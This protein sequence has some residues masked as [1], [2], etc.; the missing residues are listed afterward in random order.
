MCSLTF[1]LAL[2]FAL[3]FTA[4]ESSYALVFVRVLPSSRF[5]GSKRESSSLEMAPGDTD[6]TDAV[7]QGRVIEKLL[8][9]ALKLVQK[10]Q[11][12]GADDDVEAKTGIAR[13]SFM[14][15]HKEV[16]VLDGLDA[17]TQY[18]ALPPSEYSA[19]SSNL[20]T[21]KGDGSTDTFSV[22]IPINSG[23]SR[24]SGINASAD[25]VVSPDPRN[26]EIEIKSGSIYLQASA[27]PPSERRSND[28]SADT[29]QTG[30]STESDSND[31]A[32]KKILPAWLIAEEQEGVDSL[33]ASIQAGFCVT[34]VWDTTETKSK[35]NQASLLRKKRRTFNDD[36]DDNDALP[37]SAKVQV[38]VDLNLPLR[39]DVARAL[40]FPPV[41][42][43]ITQAGTLIART[44]IMSV[45]P[46]LADLLVQDFNCRKSPQSS[47]F[48]EDE[49]L[50]KR[51]K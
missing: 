47:F 26:G 6:K 27:P 44:V 35:M 39:S 2:L 34:L 42:L 23:T 49:P 51:E 16:I 19:L 36:N 12:G 20:I 40:N 7:K 14:T 50:H 31:L 43:L 10:L 11:G 15:S 33:K 8:L 3:V 18:L 30:A 9:T 48:T 46:S 29:F 22:S 32:L 13:V 28:T 21:R 41:R 38:W 25:V 5:I 17:A 1:T 45:T 4:M 24:G 37:V